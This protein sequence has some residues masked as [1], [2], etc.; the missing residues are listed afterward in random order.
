M[1]SELL[2]SKAARLKIA[3]SKAFNL[4]NG[5]GTTAD[6]C[7]LLVD[8]PVRLHSARIVYSDATS[9]TVASANV[10]VGTAVNGTQIVAQTAYENGK[11]VGTFTALVLAS[12]FVAANAPVIV[13]H[14][15]VAATQAGEAYVEVVYSLFDD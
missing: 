2:N 1:P 4:D 15:G 10:K 9:G 12:T 6:D 8:R 14:T 11:A 7:I 5:A 3:R 13:R